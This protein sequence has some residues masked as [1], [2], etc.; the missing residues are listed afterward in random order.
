MST[1]PQESSSHVL[2][3]ELF[4]PLRAYFHGFNRLLIRVPALVVCGLFL[5]V[6]WFDLGAEYNVPALLWHAHGPSQFAGG[7]AVALLFGYLWLLT[8]LVEGRMFEPRPIFPAA[9]QR[10]AW[11]A[12]L[13]DRLVPTPPGP[14]DSFRAGLRWYLGATWLPLTVAM[15]VPVAFDPRGR[16]P[17]LAGAAATYGLVWILAVVTKGRWTRTIACFV[18]AGLA[19]AYLYYCL[20][21][22]AARWPGWQSLPGQRVNTIPPVV[23]V[24][25]LCGVVGGVC[26][27]VGYSLRRYSPVGLLAVVLWVA[28]CNWAPYKLRFPGLEAEYAD[29]A[30]AALV[31]AEEP[32]APPPGRD[33]LIVPQMYEAPDGESHRAALVAAYRRLC[34]C[35]GLPDDNSDAVPVPELYLRYRKLQLAWLYTG[36][37]WQLNPDVWAEPPAELAGMSYRALFETYRALLARVARVEEEEVLTAWRDNAAR[38]AGKA[39]DAGFRPKLAVLAIA[40]GANR[41]ALWA[42]VVLDRLERELCGGRTAGG[43]RFPQHVRLI[44]GASGGMVGAAHYVSTLDARGRHVFLGDPDRDGTWTVQRDAQGRDV[45]VDLLEKFDPP[46]QVDYLTP[47]LNRLVFRDVPYWFLPVRTYDEDRGRALEGGFEG[48]THQ[49]EQSFASLWPGERDG[50]RPSLVFSPMLV[51]DGRR[52]L[53]SNLALSYLAASEGSF[54]LDDSP[55]PADATAQQP[56]RRKQLMADRRDRYGRSAV[57]LFRLFPAAW[58][59]FRVST[60]ARMSA[61]FPYISPAV[62]LPTEPPRRVVDAAYYDNY[63]VNIAAG[64]VYHHRRWLRDNTSGVVL[65]QVRDDPSHRLRRQLQDGD[66][67]TAPGI[68]AGLQGLT[69][70]LSGVSAARFAVTSFRN[71][72]QLQVLSDWF[73]EGPGADPAFFTTV[74]FERPGRVGMNWYLSDDDAQTIRAGFDGERNPN[75]R[76]LELLK[77][78]WGRE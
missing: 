57:E 53:V 2:T 70:P 43:S 15:V 47:V 6:A 30:R 39:G 33:D 37:Q 36:L 69:S 38:R 17:F 5:A 65:I 32:E 72:E 23:S 78:W 71:D 75:R 77:E 58:D 40:G 11:Y 7:L 35:L 63:G 61:T 45:P 48:S 60:A 19:L 28:W 34:R 4:P 22:D 68:G 14:R 54:L 24:C 64:W 41:A 9:P 3:P 62:Q 46:V 52:L 29:G 31:D 76:A 56:Q 12:R 49:L 59:R 18:F 8:F 25:V 73:G 42:T 10:Y 27:L 20:L 50:W 44:A 16:W 21:L 66:E 67:P 55:E 13:I 74:V 51:E 26:G 1:D